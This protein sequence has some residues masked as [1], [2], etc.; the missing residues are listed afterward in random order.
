MGRKASEANYRIVAEVELKRAKSMQ[1]ETLN[2]V[3][4]LDK[5]L[6]KLEKFGDRGASERVARLT[7]GLKTLGGT[8]K[9]LAIDIQQSMEVFRAE[10]SAAEDDTE[11]IDAAYAKFIKTVSKLSTEFANIA[12]QAKS[13]KTAF[14][15]ELPEKEWKNFQKIMQD[16]T[17]IPKKLSGEFLV[18]R[19]KIADLNTEWQKFNAGD[20]NSKTL[21][22]LINTTAQVKAEFNSMLTAYKSTFKEFGPALN[23]SID[24]AV[25]NARNVKTELVSLQKE[26]NTLSARASTTKQSNTANNAMLEATKNINS[27]LEQRER[28]IK[29]IELIKK[30]VVD[31]TINEK[32][33]AGLVATAEKQLVSLYK[34]EQKGLEKIRELRQ[35]I[36]DIA[37]PEEKD[38]Q[39]AIIEREISK[40]KAKAEQLKINEELVKKTEQEYMLLSKEIL[41]GAL[42]PKDFNSKMTAIT[43]SSKKNLDILKDTNK[44][45]K[46]SEKELE[47]IEKLYTRIE[48]TK[49]EKDR[50]ASTKNLQEAAAQIENLKNKEKEATS[51]INQLKIAIKNATDPDEVAKYNNQLR[52][53][54]NTLRAINKE[55][56]KI[57]D[58]TTTNL[59]KMDSIK[60]IKNIGARA[61]AYAGLYTGI[62]GVVSVIKK[63]I[64]SIVEFNKA[65][66]TMSAVFDVSVKRAT[67]LEKQIVGL[68]EAYGG[69][70]DQINEAALALGRAGI[71][72]KDLID[73]TEVVIKMAKLTGD[74][75]GESASAI[76][77]YQQVFGNTHSIKD[78][79]DQLAYVANQSRLS[80]KDISTYSNYALA[81]ASA[82]NVTLE[83]INAMA[84]SFSNAG[85]N[86]STIGTQIRRLT[87]V[88]SDNSSAV[89][90]FFTTVGLSQKAFVDQLHYSAEESDKAMVMLIDRVSQLSAVDFSRAVADMDVLAKQSLTLLRNNADEI[91]MHLET[92]QAGVSGEINKAILITESYVGTW[93]RLKNSMYQATVAMGD[94]FF[95]VI[96]SAMEKLIEGVHWLTVNADNLTNAFGN[97]IT[98]VEVLAG[99]KIFGP[100]LLQVVDY[101]KLVGTARTV[102]ALWSVS[103]LKLKKGFAGLTAVMKRNPITAIATVALSAAMYFQDWADSTKE[104]T[105]EVDKLD[106]HLSGLIETS[107]KLKDSKEFEAYAANYVKILETRNKL[108]EKRSDEKTFSMAKELE[109]NKLLLA[110][111]QKQL[112][113]RKDLS[114]E[115]KKVLEDTVRSLQN[116]IKYQEASNA[117]TQKALK[118][119]KMLS[120]LVGIEKNYKLISSINAPEAQKAAKKIKDSIELFKKEIMKLRSELNSSGAKIF[121]NSFKSFDSFTKTIAK[122]FADEI[123]NLNN[124]ANNGIN[125]TEAKKNI[126]S[127]LDEITKV[128]TDKFSLFAQKTLSDQ[129]S[130]LNNSNDQVVKTLADTLQ[131]VSKEFG[132]DMEKNYQIIFKMKNIIKNAKLNPKVNEKELGIL[133]D[134]LGGI[135]QYM[136]QLNTLASTKV[137]AEMIGFNAP[138]LKDVGLSLEI[139]ANKMKALEKEQQ[140]YNSTVAGTANVT[141]KVVKLL[142]KISNIQLDYADK[143]KQIDE[144]EAS[145]AKTKDTVKSLKKVYDEST[146]PGRSKALEEYNK[147]IT[148]EL[149]LTNQLYS[150]KKELFSLSKKEVAAQ[151]A[152]ASAY[153]EAE[154]KR[155]KALAKNSKAAKKAAEQYKKLQERIRNALLA[156]DMK[157]YA[158]S[159]K[160]AQDRAKALADTAGDLNAEQKRVNE[161]TSEYSKVLAKLERAQS[162]MMDYEK[163]YKT[164]SDNLANAKEQADNLLRSIDDLRAKKATMSEEELAELKRL[165]KLYAQ[166]QGNVVAFMQAQ[167]A[168][169][170]G[171]N[172]QH[173][174]VIEYLKR[175]KKEEADLNQKLIEM[176]SSKFMSK[177]EKTR[178]DLTTKYLRLRNK[179]IETYKHDKAALTQHLAILDAVIK[180]ETE[181]YTNA[182]KFST[183]FQSAMDKFKKDAK[184]TLFDFGEEVGTTF[185]DSM[186]SSLDSFFDYTSESWMNWG[187]LAKSVIH[188]V[189]KTLIHELLSKSI[190]SQL[191]SLFSFGYNSPG[192]GIGSSMGVMGL[193]GSF[194]GFSNMFGSGAVNTGAS[195]SA[196]N[197]AMVN[198]ITSQAVTKATTTALTDAGAVFKKTFADFT[199]SN[200]AGPTIQAAQQ[201]TNSSTELAS[202]S[203]A[204]ATSAG[205][206]GQTAGTLGASSAELGQTAGLFGA[207]GYLATG[208]NTL[209]QAIADAGFASGG[210][211]VAG[212]G[213]LASGT[214]TAGVGGAF[215]AGQ[216]AAGGVAGWLTGYIGDAI[217]GVETHAPEA[218]AIGAA[219]GTAIMPG[220]GTAVGAILGSVIG[221]LQ[222]KHWK[223]TGMGLKTV[224]DE[225]ST[226]IE[227]NIIEMYKEYEKKS[228]FKTSKSSKSEK[229]QI[230]TGYLDDTQ[231]T[232]LAMTTDFKKIITSINTVFN[233]LSD[234]FKGFI[235]EAGKY[236]SKNSADKLV[237]SAIHQ[238]Y[239]GIE[240]TKQSWANDF[241]KL[242]KEVGKVSLG[243]Y[244]SIDYTIDSKKVGEGLAKIDE[245]LKKDLPDNVKASIIKYRD[246]IISAFDTWTSG[247][248]DRKNARVVQKLYKDVVEN[249]DRIGNAIEEAINTD[250]TG[251]ADSIAQNW[252]DRAK[253]ADKSVYEF[254]MEKMQAYTDVLNQAKVTSGAISVNE[255]NFQTASTNLDNIVASYN[256]QFNKTLAQIEQAFS[257][258]N[259]SLLDAQIKGSNSLDEVGKA[260]QRFLTRSTNFKLE[261]DK[262]DFNNMDLSEY[263]KLNKL[264]NDNIVLTADQTEA[265]TALGDSLLKLEEATKQYEAMLVQNGTTLFDLLDKVNGSN[266][267][268][269]LK[270]ATVAQSLGIDE[271]AVIDMTKETFVQMINKALGGLNPSELAG[272]IKMSPAQFTEWKAQ[273]QEYANLT[274]EE[275]QALQDLLDIHPEWV[276][277][278]KSAHEQLVGVT[279][280]MFGLVQI[281]DKYQGTARASTLEVENAMRV[282]G[283][284]TL[285]DKAYV[286]VLKEKIRNQ[287]DLTD[288]ELEAIRI[289]DASLS[290]I[291][292]MMKDAVDN[293]NKTAEANGYTNNP[294]EQAIAYHEAAISGLE[295]SISAIDSQIAG[296][297]SQIDA[298]ENQISGLND[299]I[300]VYQ[301]QID[302]INSQIDVYKNQISDLNDQIQVYQDQIDTISRQIGDYRDQIEVLNHQ[303]Q[304]YRDQIAAIND[305]IN[306]YKDQ[307]SALND[308]IS[309]YKD[310]IKDLNAQ[311]KDYQDRIKNIDS[312]IKSFDGVIKSLQ[313]SIDAIYGTKMNGLDNLRY[314][315]MLYRQSKDELSIAKAAFDA[316]REN[317]DAA[318]KYVTALNEFNKAAGN[319]ASALSKDKSMAG[320]FD[321]N[322]KRLLIASDMGKAQIDVGNEKDN[323]QGLKDSLEALVTP[324]QNQVDALNSLI[325]QKQN[326]INSIENLIKPLEDQIKGIEQ[327]FIKPLEQQIKAIEDLIW[328]LEQQIKQIQKDNIR[329][330]Q[331][332]IKVIERFDI[333]PLEDQIKM[334]QTV[335]IQPLKDQIAAIKDL[336]KPLKDQIDILNAQKKQLQD[337]INYH[338]NAIDAIKKEEEESKKLL[339]KIFEQ[340]GQQVKTLEDKNGNVHNI[341][342]QGFMSDVMGDAASALGDAIGDVVTRMQES[343]VGNN[344]TGDLMNPA[345]FGVMDWNKD[346]LIDAVRTVSGDGSSV[347]RYDWNNDGTIDVEYSFDSS[348]VL[349]DIAYNTQVTS[350][351]LSGQ[352]KDA[353]DKVAETNQ[354]LNNSWISGDF[355]TKLNQTKV[356]DSGGPAVMQFMGYAQN[357]DAYAKNLDTYSQVGELSPDY[358]SK[359]DESV[360]ALLDNANAYLSAGG[361]ASTA[362]GID[363][364]SMGD[365]SSMTAN[366]LAFKQYT[367]TLLTAT[368]KFNESMSTLLN[369]DINSVGKEEFDKYMNDAETARNEAILAAQEYTKKSIETSIETIKTSSTTLGDGIKNVFTS[370]QQNIGDFLVNDD[371]TKTYFQNM[372]DGIAQPIASAMTGYL[373]SIKP[374]ITNTG[375]DV[376]D[377]ADATIS[378]SV[379]AT[380]DAL[381]QSTLAVTGG[382]NTIQNATTQ[383]LDALKTGNQTLIDNAK[384]QY[385][386]VISNI[387]SVTAGAVDANVQTASDS[388][389]TVIDTTTGLVQTSIDSGNQT[390]MAIAGQ[391]SASTT[392][393]VSQMQTE[394]AAT[395]AN[396]TKLIN[397]AV[398]SANAA[399][400]AAGGDAKTT[401]EKPKTKTKTGKGILKTAFEGIDNTAG[402]ITQPSSSTTSEPDTYDE[403]NMPHYYGWGFSPAGYASGG[404][405]GSNPTDSLSGVVHGQE[406][407]MNAEATK[408]IGVN[409]LEAMNSGGSSTFDTMVDILKAISSE[410]VSMKT[411]LASQNE[412][413]LAVNEDTNFYVKNQ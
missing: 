72:E 148:K 85:L 118:L 143:S 331:D 385:Q 297:Q 240:D 7:E 398:A 99:L 138:Q 255:L 328:P 147:A 295:G 346:G 42:L 353:L 310:S 232:Y 368:Q 204:L 271:Q 291:K 270:I 251:T 300:D 12:T 182:N 225:L 332:M 16:S 176:Y 376:V 158:A 391:V 161:S 111:L 321:R 192:G 31:G 97:F 248:Y 404:Y 173:Q 24:N 393:W 293:F 146:G 413:L 395:Q 286:A 247:N 228:W 288:V 141:D 18:I 213:D 106:K 195:T 197:L 202:A 116:K 157:T 257:D 188:D 88:F 23:V 218:G 63:G 287:E 94:K 170:A 212:F 256:E 238:A 187:D 109:E 122:R 410:L 194:G 357:L 249:F 28:L 22:S 272:L 315:E 259:N 105:S 13:V 100:L 220:V 140:N 180:K 407:V 36:Y 289:I 344:N 217:L 168:A 80:T 102:T 183:G 318:D 324:L 377:T 19:S 75:I 70:V 388:V 308:E 341:D 239:A 73:A 46:D 383:Y 4:D 167:N 3:K 304:G 57:A 159:F 66:M 1:S 211:F 338:K 382:L 403:K 81:A 110:G 384:T 58:T 361:D 267:N 34:D 221:G 71:A 234:S 306:I 312:I 352:L 399:I 367:E 327:A 108:N 164:Q 322:Y 151:Q 92:L 354:S 233:N 401:D 179:V 121:D 277:Q 33:A 44:L 155:E 60:W 21:E 283:M 264:I 356:E 196:A 329:P 178:I 373:D 262:I 348:G 25:R 209:A 371:T 349:Q 314:L 40:L 364:L 298:Y 165:E 103:L 134:T 128:M 67:T 117:E 241:H 78:L 203:G 160:I 355:F 378:A 333:K 281:L 260:V 254:F 231:I 350:D 242:N 252:K 149:S 132:T 406:F 65:V 214:A 370:F 375:I 76:I 400:V 374:V 273:H 290:H 77:T 83:A 387:G 152:L 79:G 200:T 32:T 74:S 337:L 27:I 54:V 131:K 29:R 351:M 299:Q 6:N 119:Q 340:G 11:A 120:G 282:L 39:L 224:Q 26:I 89:S 55:Q 343:F 334:I 177:Y 285:T 145:L 112:K 326:E 68:G 279:D 323:L 397:D 59:K 296:L 411:T 320:L 115:T 372:V 389:A 215:A 392:Q 268:K 208:M 358:F 394:L 347:L 174:K 345:G 185:T 303:I 275:I 311:I 172:A 56:A 50:W 201:L 93:E 86:A 2:I 339:L 150:S 144:L 47:K 91:K 316:N 219:V 17:K 191:A 210:S 294:Y 258:K 133:K 156:G 381:Q 30:K 365:V 199:A 175:Q 171:R 49:N 53:E 366:G 90:K 336:E 193:L 325:E 265:F 227:S 114:D 301:G 330:L 130:P 266:L 107:K 38:N 278:L 126:I 409:N 162:A 186:T 284:S 153:V 139:L 8:S 250:I 307:I 206:L 181:R 235:V 390:M 362:S 136:T 317:K 61:M 127:D 369:S 363:G 405:T 216:V 263:V 123:K 129:L 226:K 51:A 104:T 9:H 360:A 37:N 142:A 386:A 223:L 244:A 229:V 198:E 246:S 359:I 309:E 124:L 280:Q 261:F 253:A 154:I 412:Q 15:S 113:Y 135:L 222:G 64:G 163:A 190:T 20:A 396:A 292:K 274:Q 137:S 101:I 342:I 52:E 243:A 230:D 408:S 14:G 84:T 236:S 237:L 207:G 5:I 269:K 98:T 166:A 313:S 302:D 125:I 35:Q 48:K 169:A 305:Q 41:H 379:A 82:S 184:T 245:V 205:T 69:T 319:Y 95:P 45:Y 10:L 87:N 402:N 189:A 43:E 380:G 335:Y 96:K 62:Y 276:N